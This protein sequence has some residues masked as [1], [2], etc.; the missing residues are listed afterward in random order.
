V[1]TKRRLE[2]QNKKSQTPKEEAYNKAQLPRNS[3]SMTP[4][5]SISLIKRGSA[6]RE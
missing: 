5:M 3:S 1:I 2:G 6:I 4:E